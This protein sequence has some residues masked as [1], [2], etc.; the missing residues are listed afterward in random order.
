MQREVEARHNESSGHAIAGVWAKSLSGFEKLRNT[1]ADFSSQF[2]SI[3]SSAA[4]L[5]FHPDLLSLATLSSCCIGILGPAQVYLRLHLYRPY[6][7]P[8]PK[9]IAPSPSKPSYLINHQHRFFSRKASSRAYLERR[10]LSRDRSFNLL[11][12]A[13][14]S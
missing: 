4:L 1:P 6:A 5:V 14:R 12:L 11:P 10:C 13:Y 7:P 2:C 8:S 3:C 9:P